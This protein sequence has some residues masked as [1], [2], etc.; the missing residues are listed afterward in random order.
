MAE[1][2]LVVCSRLRV[3]RSK[4]LALL[5]DDWKALRYRAINTKEFQLY[6]EI[7]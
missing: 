5:I 4:C 3:G 2:G 7:S 1:L 6:F